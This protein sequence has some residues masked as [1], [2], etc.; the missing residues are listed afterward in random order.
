MRAPPCWCGLPL[1]RPALLFADCAVRV[2]RSAWGRL[3]VC[4]SGERPS[5]SSGGRRQAVGKGFCPTCAKAGPC[6]FIHSSFPIPIY[7][8]RTLIS[9]CFSLGRFRSSDSGPPGVR[10]EQQIGGVVIRSPGR[11]GVGVDVQFCPRFCWLIS[12]R[13][14]FT[15]EATGHGTSCMSRGEVTRATRRRLHN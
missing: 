6:H 8:S 15:D 9:S 4:G 3:A 13:C 2:R 10:E 5:R 7:F 14:G 1:P 11:G 12:S